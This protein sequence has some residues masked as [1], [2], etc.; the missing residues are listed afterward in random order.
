M[1]ERIKHL[2][3][4]LDMTQ[5]EFAE[6]I[7]VK[8]NTIAQYEIG[9]NEPIDSIFSLICREF[10]VNPE[11][12]RNGEGEMFIVLPEEDEYFAAATEISN[13]NDTFAMNAIIEYWKLDRASKDA[14]K[15]YIMSLADKCKKDEQV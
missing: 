10:N 2:R 7:G 6:R 5:Q 14:I 13:D 12:L 11:W 4:T 9:R 15:N 1:N 8:R 3:K